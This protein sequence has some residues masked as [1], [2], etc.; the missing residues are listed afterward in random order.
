MYMHFIVMSNADEL[1]FY[2]RALFKKHLSPQSAARLATQVTEKAQS[3]GLRSR[4]R[5]EPTMEPLP[6][7]R[8]SMA[9]AQGERR[10]AREI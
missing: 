3:G 7:R 5:S 1:I 6:I 9:V 4:L 10:P 2:Q 8:F